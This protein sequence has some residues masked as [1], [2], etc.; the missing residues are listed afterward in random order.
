M[1]PRQL[2][3]THRKLTGQEADQILRGGIIRSKKNPKDFALTHA[4]R[5]RF[6]HGVR[7]VPKFPSGYKPESDTD[8]IKRNPSGFPGYKERHAKKSILGKAKSRSRILGDSY[9]SAWNKANRQPGGGAY[10]PIKTKQGTRQ[11]R[12][13]HLKGAGIVGA[14]ALA[15]GAG[16]YGYKK[17]KERRQKS[18]KFTQPTMNTLRPTTPLLGKL[19]RKSKGYKKYMKVNQKSGNQGTLY[20]EDLLEYADR[21]YRAKSTHKAGIR[22]YIPGTK[23]RRRRKTVQRQFDYLK[24]RTGSK[25]DAV[26]V[27]SPE[28]GGIVTIRRKRKRFLPDRYTKQHNRLVG[29]ARK[30]GGKWKPLALEN[31]SVF[32]ELLLDYCEGRADFSPR[33]EDRIVNL[34]NKAILGYGYP[35]KGI[36]LPGRRK[37]DKDK[38]R[39]LYSTY[40][41]RKGKKTTRAGAW[42]LR[43]DIHGLKKD[44][45]NAHKL[46]ARMEKRRK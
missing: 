30:K 17:L 43:P 4:G 32:G 39:R 40:H 20:S 10:P 1:M 35:R 15:I 44:I 18:K 27:A 45:K 26:G 41:K 33:Y 46:K 34:P 28:R 36:G 23:A 12:R 14:G 31:K 6:K 38:P 16:I 8:F 9:R 3:S 2:K 29:R 21:F 11:F 42:R 37:P 25:G 22:Q 5:Q 7:K 24:K 13:Q 19:A